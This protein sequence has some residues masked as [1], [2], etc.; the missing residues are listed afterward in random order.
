VRF[1]LQLTPQREE[2]TPQAEAA[3]RN[4]PE[5]A[6]RQFLAEYFKPK[7]R[8]DQNTQCREYIF[9]VRGV[10]V[11]ALSGTFKETSNDTESDAFGLVE[12]CEEKREETWTSQGL[13]AE[14]EEWLKKKNI[15]VRVFIDPKS[16]QIKWVKPQGPVSAKSAI[17]KEYSIDCT[18]R[19]GHPP[20]TRYEPYN[21]SK[22]ETRNFVWKV[23]EI[24]ENFDGLPMSPDWQAKGVGETGANGEGQ[25]ERSLD[26]SLGGESGEKGT[27]RGK[28]TKKIEWELQLDILPAP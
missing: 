8:F 22:Q 10:S 26:K 24:S 7:V 16:K 25:N 4:V 2:L 19:K 11:Q 6:K 21:D 17:A 9:R 14:T 1:L 27:L 28:E 20:E 5:E 18:Q 12:K 15:E 23:Q 3:L 13:S